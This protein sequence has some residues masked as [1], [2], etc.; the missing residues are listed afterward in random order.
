MTAHGMV[1]IIKMPMKTDHQ[2]MDTATW[3]LN[4][5]LEV[6]SDRGIISGR[7]DL[8]QHPI[9]EIRAEVKLT[10]KGFRL[11]STFSRS[12]RGSPYG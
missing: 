11:P 12:E 5:R 4:Y 1:L 2:F 8:R 3:A 10:G 9:P 7:R 6:V